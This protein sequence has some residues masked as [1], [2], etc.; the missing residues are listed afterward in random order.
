MYHSTLGSRVREKKKKRVT[1]VDVREHADPVA[2]P[3]FRIRLEP[4]IHIRLD[5][6]IRIK[7]ELSVPHIHIK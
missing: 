5:P 1:E 3:R 6:R 7:S 4:R 2:A